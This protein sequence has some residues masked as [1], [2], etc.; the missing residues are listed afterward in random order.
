MI[1]ARPSQL[2]VLVC[3]ASELSR[4]F[5]A[6]RRAKRLGHAPT[7]AQIFKRA[8]RVFKAQIYYRMVRGGSEHP[9]RKWRSLIAKKE[10]AAGCSFAA[11]QIASIDHELACDFGKRVAL[12]CMV[13]LDLNPSLPLNPGE[14]DV[15]VRRSG[16]SAKRHCEPRRPSL[17]D[18]DSA[19]HSMKSC[20]PFAEVQ[21]EGRH[22]RRCLAPVPD[23]GLTPGMATGSATKPLDNHAVFALRGLGQLVTNALP[24]AHAASAA[25]R[26]RESCFSSAALP[27]QPALA[28]LTSTGDS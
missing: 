19:F 21:F 4:T 25:A 8:V 11:R 23:E 18:R 17:A 16:R 24:R 12:L 7:W 3:I 10:F 20:Q 13:V 27:C 2:H 26:F 1:A 6:P 9:K 5:F 14:S 28:C 15:F 22:I